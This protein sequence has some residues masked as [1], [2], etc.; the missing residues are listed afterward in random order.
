MKSAIVVAVSALLIIVTNS[1]KRSFTCRCHSVWYQNVS[2]DGWV[3]EPIEAK[4]RK[5]AEKDCL[6]KVKPQVDGPD[7]CML[8]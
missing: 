3:D 6:A 4:S 2:K 7:K 1:C 5:A 8:K